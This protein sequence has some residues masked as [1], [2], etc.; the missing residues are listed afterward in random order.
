MDCLGN[1][2]ENDIRYSPLRPGFKPVLVDFLNPKEQEFVGRSINIFKT[3][4]EELV[5]L[6]P[7]PSPYPHLAHQELYEILPKEKDHS[8]RFI[9]IPEHKPHKEEEIQLCGE[10]NKFK[11]V[12]N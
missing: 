4:V 2:M 8:P 3:S 11:L 7:F 12:M 9:W 1:P 10:A 5:S 6:E